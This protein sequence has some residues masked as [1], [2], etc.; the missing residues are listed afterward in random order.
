[1]TM[2]KAWPSRHDHFFKI[3]FGNCDVV[4]KFLIDHLPH[5]ILKHFNMM[6][7]KLAQVVLPSRVSMRQADLVLSVLTNEQSPSRAYFLIEHKSYVD[8]HVPWQL[9]RYICAI[10]DMHRNRYPKETLYPTIV[11]L[12]CYHGINPIHKP[13]NVFR[14]FADTS[15]ELKRSICDGFRVLDFGKISD[16]QYLSNGWTNLGA[17]VH[18]HIRNPNLLTKLDEAG[19]LLKDAVVNG[20]VTEVEVMLDYILAK[21]PDIDA[22]ALQALV[23]KHVSDQLGEYVM[24]AAD[25]L[26][27]QGREEGIAQGIAQGMKKGVNKGQ[28]K[29]IKRLAK[30]GLGVQFIAQHTGFSPEQINIMVS[31]HAEED[32]S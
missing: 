26:I 1:M 7:L 28:Q 9:C 8:A 31:E 19:Q 29:I 5:T 27:G 16:H 32:A 23:I 14:L 12:I 22:Q 10:I 30:S 15:I 3:W 21:G 18:K 20:Y 2:L 4:R 11:P 25:V 24:S 13:L 6:T 17:Y